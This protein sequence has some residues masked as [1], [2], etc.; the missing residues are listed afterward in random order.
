MQYSGYSKES[1][2]E[3]KQQG[4]ERKRGKKTNSHPIPWAAA[5]LKLRQAVFATEGIAHITLAVEKGEKNKMLKIPLLTILPSFA[6]RRMTL[7][8]EFS[9]KEI[10]M[11]FQCI[12]DLLREAILGPCTASKTVAR[13]VFINI[14]HISKGE[15]LYFSGTELSDEQ[16]LLLVSRDAKEE[17]RV[18]EG[19][20]PDIDGGKWMSN[21]RVAKFVKHIETQKKDSWTLPSKSVGNMKEERP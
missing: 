5:C 1:T 8:K 20:A 18:K 7:E 11:T 4:K 16:E 17:M 10:I 19:R 3:Q 2:T 14:E 9:E 6:D 21:E 13:A 12:L 15:S